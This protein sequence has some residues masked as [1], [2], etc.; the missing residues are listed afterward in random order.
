MLRYNL[1]FL[2]QKYLISSCDTNNIDVIIVASKSTI[3]FDVIE[4]IIN[5]SISTNIA[6]LISELEEKLK[7]LFH[8]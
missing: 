7:S 3:I 1:S 2:M 4:K 8:R 6:T 5:K